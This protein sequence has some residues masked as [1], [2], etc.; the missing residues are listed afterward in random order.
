MKDIGIVG[1]SGYT[2]GEM[3]RL[4]SGHRQIRAAW[5]TS[6]TYAGRGVEVAFPYLRDF[7]GLTFAEPDLARIPD[8]LE[9]VMVALPHTEA[10]EVVP[11]LLDRGIKV[12]D[13]SADFRLGA[14]AVYTSWYGREHIAPHLLEEAVYGLTE[15]YRDRI[16]SSRLVANPGCYPTAALLALLPLVARGLVGE[17]EIIVDAKSGVSGAGRSPRQ[18]TLFA[19]ANESLTPYLAGRHRHLPEM[20]QE[21]GKAAEKE[22]ALTFVPHLVP[23]SRGLLETIYLSLI[24]GAGPAD[25]EA[26]YREDYAGEPF[27]KVLP[28]GA[29]PSVRD[30]AGTNLCRI[31]FS[32]DPRGGRMIVVAAIDNLV[33]GA[34]GQALQN[35]N[36]MLG[37]PEGAGLEGPGLFP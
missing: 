13:L 12:V 2:G 37:L 28:Q 16:A 8:G 1:G 32:D 14:A 5:V 27:V 33:K 18:D 31:G 24:P 23:L 4:L 7:T 21:L 10:M 15:R 22:V 26:A 9:A 3:L 35:L 30:V 29:L 19:E 25:I 34:S 36:L 11:L 6:R 17:G 20:E